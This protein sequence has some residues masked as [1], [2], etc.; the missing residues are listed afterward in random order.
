MTDYSFA[1]GNRG[2]IAKF[3]IASAAAAVMLVSGTGA[4]MGQVVGDAAP[5]FTVDTFDG[6]HTLSD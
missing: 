4:L 6:K 2:A 5:D 1:G 3:L